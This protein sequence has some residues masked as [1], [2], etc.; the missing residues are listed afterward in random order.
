MRELKQNKHFSEYKI[1]HIRMLV[2]IFVDA[3]R[4]KSLSKM[5]KGDKLMNVLQT[6][7]RKFID[8]NKK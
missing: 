5:Q 8:N 2:Q 7:L 1:D 3:D 4:K 6:H